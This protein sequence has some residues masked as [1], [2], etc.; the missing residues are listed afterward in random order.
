MSNWAIVAAIAV[1]AATVATIAYV[2][3][4]QHET[5]VLRNDAD[6]AVRL[7]ELAGTDAVRLAAVDEF[8]TA[9]YERL[10]YTRAVGPRFRA[11]AWALLGAVLSTAGVLLLDGNSST[12]SVVAWAAAIVLAIGFGVAAVVFL[13]LAGYAALTTPRVSFAESYESAEADQE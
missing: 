13:A 6:L 8:E 1:L 3:Y 2:R 10:F 5:S 7:R 12:A 11:A 4:R 9:V